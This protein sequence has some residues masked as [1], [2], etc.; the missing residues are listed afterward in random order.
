[1]WP[2]TSNNIANI[3][4][5]LIVIPLAFLLLEDVYHCI[6]VM[7]DPNVGGVYGSFHE[8][9]QHVVKVTGWLVAG[10]AFEVGVGVR[11][12]CHVSEVQEGETN[13]TQAE[14]SRLPLYS[15]SSYAIQRVI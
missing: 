8:G 13:G 2:P 11:K 1:M 15:V 14:A 12:C 9:L 7:L 6:A 4:L 10:W 5:D 3:A